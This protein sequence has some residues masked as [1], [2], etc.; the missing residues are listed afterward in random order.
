[1]ILF[2]NVSHISL[3]IIVKAH[4]DL[5]YSSD[6][7]KQRAMDFSNVAQQERVSFAL[8][9]RTLDL[10]L[11]FFADPHF[12]S[13][14]AICLTYFISLVTVGSNSLA[15]NTISNDITTTMNA[16]VHWSRGRTESCKK[17]MYTAMNN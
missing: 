11:S 3:L 10:C 15:V 7:T 1:M 4:L 6:T 5:Y 9:H 8:E 16:L 2:Q 12:H 14:H 17:P 13:T